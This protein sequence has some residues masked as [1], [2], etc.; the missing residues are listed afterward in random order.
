MAL[1]KPVLA[2]WVFLLP[3]SSTTPNL[4]VLTGKLVRDV[5]TKRRR[6]CKKGPAAGLHQSRACVSCFGANSRRVR[7]SHSSSLFWLLAPSAQHK[8]WSTVWKYSSVCHHINMIWHYQTTADRSINRSIFVYHHHVRQVCWSEANMTAPA[9]QKRVHAAEY[10][11]RS[12]PF[13]VVMWHC[14]LPGDH[15]CANLQRS[16]RSSREHKVRPPPLILV[17]ARLPY[18]LCCCL[19]EQSAQTH[20]LCL[21]Q[22]RCKQDCV[23]MCAFNNVCVCV[24]V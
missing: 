24:C 5:P 9:G 3:D 16:K 10:N 21:L 13:S 22:I 4:N 14:W 12:L 7:Q 23:C 15:L 18:R 8:H 20:F 1:S 11:S 6:T 19:T 17:L 2:S